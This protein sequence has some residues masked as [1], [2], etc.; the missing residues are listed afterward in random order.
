MPG[1][2]QIAGQFLRKLRFSIVSSPQT[3]KAGRRFET[4]RARHVTT[5]CR[6]TSTL[7]LWRA[8]S[9]LLAF[10]RLTMSASAILPNTPP[11]R[12]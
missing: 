1:T 6:S 12:A 9:R 2:P 4:R 11:G 3:G 8:S 7:K 5:Y 10:M